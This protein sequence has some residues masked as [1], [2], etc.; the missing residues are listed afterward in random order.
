MPME[1]RL[2][3]N[4]RAITRCLDAHSGPNL[5]PLILTL[6]PDLCF[7]HTCQRWHIHGRLPG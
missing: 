6:Y 4:F 5:R 3:V 1:G 2:A 7:T